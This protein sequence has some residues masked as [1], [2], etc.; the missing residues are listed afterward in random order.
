M[1]VFNTWAA[2]EQG[3]SAAAHVLYSAT[4]ALL[5]RLM[6]G[7]AAEV[8]SGGGTGGSSAEGGAGIP[9]TLAAFDGAWAEYLA[10]FA[11]WKRHDAAALEVC[12]RMT[13]LRVYH[14]K[15]RR[16]CLAEHCDTCIAVLNMRRHTCMPSDSCVSLPGHV[17]S[18][19]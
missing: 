12:P 7:P 17:G 1:T 18:V 4:A 10:L 16:Q 19:V 15:R 11:A 6:A 2:R 9:E 8:S 14:L 5:T 3:L 13:T